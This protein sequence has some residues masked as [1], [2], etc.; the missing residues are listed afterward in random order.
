LRY[1][2]GATLFALCGEKHDN[3][4]EYREKVNCFFHANGEKIGG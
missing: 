2:L 4:I 3:L 1:A